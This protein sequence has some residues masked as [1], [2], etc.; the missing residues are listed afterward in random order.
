MRFEILVPALGPN[1]HEATFVT[2]LKNVGDQV[3]KGE[4]IAEVMTD[5]VNIDVEA[6][7]AGVLTELAAQP[8]QVL[9]LDSVLGVIDAAQGAHTGDSQ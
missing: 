7:A 3:E 9:G 4:P 1:M 2:W 6:P 8:E 5:K